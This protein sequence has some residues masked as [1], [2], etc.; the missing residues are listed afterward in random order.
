MWRKPASRKLQ[1]TLV[2][3]KVKFINKAR[4]KKYSFLNSGGD[5]RVIR[6]LVAGV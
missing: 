6:E 3:P 2:K 4:S 1:H 5:L